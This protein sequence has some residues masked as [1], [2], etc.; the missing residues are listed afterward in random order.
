MAEASKAALCLQVKHPRCEAT[1]FKC[2]EG[3]RV[4]LLSCKRQ[5]ASHG[6]Y[7]TRLS[8]LLDKA[9]DIP[10]DSWWESGGFIY[11]AGVVTGMGVVLSG[12]WALSKMN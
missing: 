1:L 5:L 6:E 11:G 8:G 7:N 3:A 4:S 9:L 10:D 12:A 2:E